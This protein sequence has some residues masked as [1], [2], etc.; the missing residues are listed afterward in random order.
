MPRIKPTSG[1]M[2]T[3][4]IARASIMTIAMTTTAVSV[5]KPLQSKQNPTRTEAVRAA[6]ARMTRRGSLQKQREALKG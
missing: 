1:P 4:P 5:K 2:R 3:Q 6:K